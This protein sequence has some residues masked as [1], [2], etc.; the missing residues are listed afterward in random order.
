MKSFTVTVFRTESTKKTI[1]AETEQEAFEKLSYLVEETTGC[2]RNA[3][4]WL[5]SVE[6]SYLC[7]EKGR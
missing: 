7:A 6:G 2:P 1:R 5:G 4:R 3:E